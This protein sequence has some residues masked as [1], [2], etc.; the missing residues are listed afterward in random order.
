MKTRGRRTNE[1][2]LYRLFV[3]VRQRNE[4]RITY[5]YEAKAKYYH[6]KFARS[7][8]LGVSSLFLDFLAGKRNTNH[9]ARGMEKKDIIIIY[10]FSFRYPLKCFATSLFC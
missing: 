4:E 5:E 7:E 2:R 6:Q 10:L 3:V 8:A 1:T 9:V